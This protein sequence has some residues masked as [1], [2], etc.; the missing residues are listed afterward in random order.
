M[1]ADRP[2][3]HPGRDGLTLTAMVTRLVD[4]P[5]VVLHTAVPS[6]A[7]SVAGALAGATAVVGKAEPRLA[8]LTGI[9]AA[10]TAPRGPAQVG[11]EVRGR[12]LG[13]L[14]PEDR[15]VAAMR[16]AGTPVAAIAQALGI[17]PPQAGRRLDAI[18]VAL[19]GSE[20]VGRLER[21]TA[22]PSPAPRQRRPRR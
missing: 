6:D 9:R 13:R 15:A 12:V 1:A 10:A 3:H 18:L 4:A 21:P 7:L 14:G 16:L 22:A 17:T 2:G 11:L 5:R 19:T 20:D 8:L